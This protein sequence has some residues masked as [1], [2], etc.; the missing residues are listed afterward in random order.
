M[1]RLGSIVVK[2][3]VV[4]IAGVLAVRATQKLLDNSIVVYMFEKVALPS[5]AT[6]SFTELSFP[7]MGEMR[8]ATNLIAKSTF[9][10]RLNAR[11]FGD[12]A[13]TPLKSS[14][15][16]ATF[17]KSTRA[18]NPTSD[19][20]EQASMRTLDSAGTL[21]QSIQERSASSRVLLK[22]TV[23]ND[24]CN[25]F[26]C[27]GSSGNSLLFTPASVASMVLM[28]YETTPGDHFRVPVSVKDPVVEPGAFHGAHCLSFELIITDEVFYTTVNFVFPKR[29]RIVSFDHQNVGVFRP[30]AAG[31]Q[32]RG[33]GSSSTN[34]M[35]WDLGT[36]LRGDAANVS[37][38][39]KMQQQ[40]Q[41][42][43]PQHPTN[44]LLPDGTVADLRLAPDFG[45]QLAH[46]RFV[47]NYVFTNEAGAILVSAGL[48]ED[49]V[50]EQGKNNNN[51]NK[52]NRRERRAAARAAG[53]LS[54]SSP[55]Y[56]KGGSVATTAD[57]D[58]YTHEPVMPGIYLNYSTASTASGLEV[59]KL[60]P[61]NTTFNWSYPFQSNG[62][63]SRGLDTLFRPKM[64]KEISIVTAFSQ[65]V[66]VESRL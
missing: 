42:Q 21:D 48:G 24:V 61:R 2:S 38:R 22:N 34:E 8:I 26:T 40:Q 30:S 12:D 50:L 10:L 55:N 51:S 27:F 15:S 44:T 5:E 3:A 46:V 31:G 9:Y 6:D 59:R 7:V 53:N 49:E 4:V 54:R 16:S 32:Q 45:S 60:E 19:A 43:A 47:V 62:W 17:A 56:K 64:R 14:G 52:A 23:L 36:F 37:N 20:E 29:C 57:E 13:A 65:V 11:F 39:K 63:L 58:D 41:Q 35:V 66:K 33:D 18:S 28:Q 1:L 25:T